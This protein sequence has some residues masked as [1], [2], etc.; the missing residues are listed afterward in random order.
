MHDQQNDAGKLDICPIYI[1]SCYWKFTT[2]KLMLQITG[3]GGLSEDVVESDD[4]NIDY[5][6]TLAL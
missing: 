6:D 5:P 2:G 3:L 4:V 1:L